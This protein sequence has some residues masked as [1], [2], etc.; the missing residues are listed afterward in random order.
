MVGVAGREVET[1][2]YTRASMSGA[3]LAIRP[4]GKE[5]RGPRIGR[6]GWPCMPRKGKPALKEVSQ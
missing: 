1:I 6:K 2:M 4:V 3:N 5:L